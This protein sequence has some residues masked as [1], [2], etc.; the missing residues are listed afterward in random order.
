MGYE[1]GSISGRY[2]DGGESNALRMPE[3]GVKQQGE[4]ALEFEQLHKASEEMRGFVD[5]LES[6]LTPIL[7]PETGPQAETSSAPEPVR[8]PLAETIHR[9]TSDITSASARLRY[10]L[11]RIEL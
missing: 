10:V 6:R 5:Q 4:I 3:M 9:R 7:T 8:T 1:T 11:G 2:V